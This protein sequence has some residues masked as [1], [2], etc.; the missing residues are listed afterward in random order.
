MRHQK[1][2]RHVRAEQGK[3]QSR[4]GFNAEASPTGVGW[5]LV[6]DAN[7]FQAIP[8]VAQLLSS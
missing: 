5:S 7:L 4:Q 6:Y 1:K 8:S 3:N 2:A